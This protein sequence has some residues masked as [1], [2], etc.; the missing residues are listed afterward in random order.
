MSNRI[1]PWLAWSTW[2]GAVVCLALSLPLLYQAND[3]VTL[4][5]QILFGLGFLP[6][7]TV[8]AIIASRQPQNPVGWIF[9]AVALAFLGAFAVEYAR[10]S[11]VVRPGALPGGEWMAWLGSW[12]GNPG[13]YLVFTFALLLFPDGRLLSPRWRPVAWVAAGWIVLN[14]LGTALAPGPM[15]EE[16]PAVHNPIGIEG[17]TGITELFLALEGPVLVSLATLSFLSIALRFRR[18]RAEERQQLKWFAYAVALLILG[19]TFLIVLDSLQPETS[20]RRVLGDAVFALLIAA[21]PI[22]VGFAILKYRLYDID[23]IIRRTLTYSLL[24]GLLALAY[25]SAVVLLQ[26]VFR[27]LAGQSQNQIA[28]VLSTLIIAALFSPLRAR[29]QRFIDRR[30]YRRK[31]DAA[32]VLSAFGADARDQTDL[33]TLAGR[34]AQVVDETM[35][36]EAVSVWLRPAPGSKA[37]GRPAAP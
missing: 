22:S 36:P 12:V 18:A 37:P 7:P 29:V 17:L 26:A 10:Y 2:T 23:V 6:F 3:P 25:F 20:T 8:G 31:Y 16:A 4:A 27:A 1:A 21:I 13:F 9:C 19:S 35:Q 14:T 34:L 24:T 11:L 33:E 32:R 30:F 15:I 28:T 5:G